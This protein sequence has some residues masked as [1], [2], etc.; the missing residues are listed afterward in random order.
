MF[1]AQYVFDNIPDLNQIVYNDRSYNACIDLM[2]RN[3]DNT[4]VEKIGEKHGYN[5]L[6]QYAMN[7]GFAQTNL[8]ANT[9]SARN[10]GQF[11]ER[12][13]AGNLF[14]AEKTSRMLSLMYSQVYRSGIPAGSTGSSVADKPGFY[15]DS[16]HDAAL[17]RSPGSTYVLVIM[18]KGPGPTAVKT[19]AQRINQTLNQ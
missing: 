17:V 6:T 13:Y 12:L 9:T 7:K 11:I 10:A 18:T 15:G 4:C 19:L 14:D 2:I 8:N 1:V 3:S 16:W 5:T